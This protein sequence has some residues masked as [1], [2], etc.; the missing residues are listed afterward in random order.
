MG[1]EGSR[2]R[3][4][5]HTESGSSVVVD[6]RIIV[7]DPTGVWI[8]DHIDPRPDPDVTVVKNN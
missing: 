2:R 5:P 1:A 8:F 3:R 6:T 7:N 4:V